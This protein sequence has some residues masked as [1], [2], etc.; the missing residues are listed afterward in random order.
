VLAFFPGI[1]P[2]KPAAPERKARGR[3]AEAAPAMPQPAARP[4]PAAPARSARS[5]RTGDAAPRPARSAAARAPTQ[6]ARGARDPAS[7]FNIGVALVGALLLIVACAALGNLLQG[8]ASRKSPGAGGQATALTVP[9]GPS[10]RV[11]AEALNLRAQPSLSSELL[12]TL[13][14][15]ARVELRG[16]LVRAEQRDWA[17]VRYGAIEGW[18]D[19]QFLRQP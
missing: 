10:T 18:V 13:P 6:A 8:S 14:G 12:A 17:P 19:S 7:H 1:E 9:V 11:A 15:G 5:Q 2:P 4:N 3:A 16:E